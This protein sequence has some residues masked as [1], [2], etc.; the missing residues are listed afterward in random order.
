MEPYFLQTERLLLRRFREED[1]AGFCAYA[2]D[3]EMSRMMG[4]EDLTDPA[5]A[6]QNFDWLLHHEPRAYAILC[7]E[8]GTVIGNL[9]IS[10]VPSFLAELEPLR[11]KKGCA[12]AFCLSRHY[13]RRGLMLEAVRAVIGRLFEEEA[14]DYINCGYFSFNEPSR[15]L[16][17]KLGFSYLAS[18]S[19][20]CGGEKVTAIDNILWRPQ[21]T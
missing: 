20:E 7:K 16:Q 18:N 13:R 11:G 4:R 9:N 12:L 17:E 5:A 2:A 8:D 1:F 19:F 10:A 3:A 15:L 21:S 14:V 6:R